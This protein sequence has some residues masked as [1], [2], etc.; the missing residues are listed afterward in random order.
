MLSPPS[1]GN[2]ATPIS[3]RG[4]S[5]T[6]HRARDRPKP[7]PAAAVG[8]RIEN[9]P[10]GPRAIPERIIAA[11][12]AMTDE[13]YDTFRIRP[14]ADRADVSPS[15]LYRYFPSK[16]ALLVAGLDLWLSR[17]LSEVERESTPM[18]EPL[19]RL[20]YLTARVTSELRRHPLLADAFVR[21]YLLAPS[22]RSDSDGLRDSISGAFAH[23]LGP[24]GARRTA[25]SDLVTDIWTANIPAIIQNRISVE[26][27]EERLERTV[28][29]A[30]LYR[31]TTVCCEPRPDLLGG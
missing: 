19:C 21:A 17:L 25:V 4:R 30:D 7:A 8:P 14:V 3:W 13:V 5:A 28:R 1:Q 22:V 6:P 24:A 12:L 31:G 2:S 16:D 29:A 11:V 27:L 10:L 9:L 20:R 18:P 23:A 15:T 26:D